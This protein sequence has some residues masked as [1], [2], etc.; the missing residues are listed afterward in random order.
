MF[1]QARCCIFV[2]FLHVPRYSKGPS[3]R[4]MSDIVRNGMLEGASVHWATSKVSLNRPKCLSPDDEPSQFAEK[5][6]EKTSAA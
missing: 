5:K 1:W 2:T 4:R 3:V 6:S